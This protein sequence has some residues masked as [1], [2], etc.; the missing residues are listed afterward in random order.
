[1]LRLATSRQLDDESL[2]PDVWKRS[3]PEA[4]GVYHQQERR[5]KADRKQHQAA[6]RLLTAELRS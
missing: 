1:M 3:H 6:L 5:D 4:V 2:L